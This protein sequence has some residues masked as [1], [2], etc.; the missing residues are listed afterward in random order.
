MENAPPTP[1]KRRP[2]R[3]PGGQLGAAHRRAAILDAASDL[4]ERR[5]YAA[6]SLGEIAAAVGV[7]KAALYHH[8]PSKEAIYAEIMRHVLGQI[9]DAIRR[10]VRA[11]GPVA[12]KIRRLTEVAVLYVQ[13]NADLDA[14]MHDAAQHL[15]PEQSRLIA[16]AHD[17]VLLALEE[18]MRDG[19]ARRELAPRDP[20][21][22]AHAYW[23]LLHGFTGRVGSEA[24]FQGRPETA[25]ALVD[26]F[27]NGAG[28][29]A[30]AAP[31]PAADPS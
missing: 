10:T 31:P 7:T 11:P 14:M 30:P 9:G 23:S 8:F 19:V 25:E 27:L 28:H 29:P 24:G 6:V 18:L 5:G 20:R 12:D 13:H 26:I 22:L 17:A 15:P 2:G 4:F 1:P 3:P 21:L 16:E